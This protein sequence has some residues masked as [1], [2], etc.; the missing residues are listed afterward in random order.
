M[1]KSV[2][3]GT[4]RVLSSKS[5]F[6]GRN[7]E[8][9]REQVVEPSGIEATRNVIAHS[10]SVVI[11]PVF[12]DRRILMIRQYRH[13][14]GQ[15]LWELV[16]GHREQN[17]TFRETAPREL[18][19]ETGYTAEKFTRLFEIYPAPGLLGEKME[20]YLAEGLRKGKPRQE[21]DEKISQRIFTLSVLEQWI[22]RGKIKDAKTVAGILYYSKFIAALGAAKQ[23]SP[24]R[25]KSR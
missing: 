16:A 23:P 21:P 17:E 25:G 9:K 6:K 12:S 7:F 10:G 18:Q 4:A 8:L 24:S 11:L 1:P 20:L 22:R 3:S 15:F 13:A 2:T 5:I 14:A 19:E